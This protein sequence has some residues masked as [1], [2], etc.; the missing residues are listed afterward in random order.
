MTNF[1]RDT[2]VSARLHTVCKQA[3]SFCDSMDDLPKG[4][5]IAAVLMT[6]KL[7]CEHLQVDLSDALG[8]VQNMVAAAEAKGNFPET[9]HYRALKAYIKTNV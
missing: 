5:Q 9:Q 8:V 4:E 1:N 7:L 3:F 2:L 6:A